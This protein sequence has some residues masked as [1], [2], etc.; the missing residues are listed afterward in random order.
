[1]GLPGNSGSHS[2]FQRIWFSQESSIGRRLKQF[3]AF[4]VPRP[5]LVAAKKRYYAALLENPRTP[6]EADMEALD[7]V[8]RPGDFA[9]DIGAFVAFTRNDCRS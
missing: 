1:M 4:V 3:V 9:L 5:L 2:M 8:V 7:Q 6:R